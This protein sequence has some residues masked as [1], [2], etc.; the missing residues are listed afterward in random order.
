MAVLFR[1]DAASYD[2]DAFG[3]VTDDY[4]RSRR[5]NTPAEWRQFAGSTGNETIFKYSVTLLD[6]VEYIVTDNATERDR[7]LNS[8]VKRGITVL[9]DGRKIEEIIL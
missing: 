3:R 6:N 2:H 5:G 9:P 4:V 8:F 7:V 1:V